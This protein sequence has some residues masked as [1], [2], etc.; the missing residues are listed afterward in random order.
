MNTDKTWLKVGVIGLLLMRSAIAQE[1]PFADLP[2][3]PKP[4][5]ISRPPARS[6][7]K[8][9]CSENFGFRKEIMSQFS[10]NQQGDGASRQSVGFEVLKKFSTATA[11]VASFNFQGRLVRRDGFNGVINDME[12]ERRPGWAFEYH[13]FYVD[14]YNILK[15]R[16]IGKLN[17]RAGRFYLP[18]GLNT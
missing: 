5:E 13:N 12:G 4:P 11:T 6:R 16:S 18:F 10:T 1:D 14:L 8:S 15:G 9:F 2:P 3:A 17:F 7:S